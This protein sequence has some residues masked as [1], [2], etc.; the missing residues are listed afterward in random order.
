MPEAIR[1]TSVTMHFVFVSMAS[2][3]Q[4]SPNSTSSLRCANMK[5]YIAR[6][7]IYLSDRAL[8]GYELLYRNSEQNM[9]PGID[10]NQATRELIYNAL[11]EF[12][13]SA[14]R[15]QYLFINLTGELLASDVPLLLNPKNTVIEILEDVAPD[16]GL[17][18]RI[19]LL[20]SKGYSLALDDFVD[21]GRFEQIFPYVDFIKVE[22]GLLT[23]ERRSG[24]AKKFGGSKKLI[25]EHIETQ[26]EY[27][28]AM[29]DGYS[30]NPSP[31]L[32]FL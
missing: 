20:K 13:F 23:P 2:S 15:G 4:T 18:E 16:P 3:F 17:I 7:P 21:D 30:M 29:R 5:L 14:P 26:A 28:S 31:L 6:Q 22:Y 25:A 27:L 32:F 11:S 19:A 8:F 12:Q 1:A 10:G 9:F 24:I